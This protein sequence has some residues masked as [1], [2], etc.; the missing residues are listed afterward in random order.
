MDRQITS[1]QGDGLVIS[2]PTGSTGYAVAA[3]A[4]VVHPQV[5]SIMVTPICPHSLSSRPLIVPA[6][7]ELK[8]AVSKN[9]RAAVNVSF[10]GRDTIQMEKG[11]E[12]FIK[13]S[14]HPTPCVCRS[15]PFDDWFDSLSEC[16]LWNSRKQQKQLNQPS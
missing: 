1:I 11:D 5:P 12:L 6:G 4:S 7:A 2:T 8:L 14:T 3:G 15:N 9:A 16:L 10:D 13:T